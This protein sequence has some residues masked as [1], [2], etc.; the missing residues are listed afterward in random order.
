MA[1]SRSGCALDLYN[2][3]PARL[4]DNVGNLNIRP[5]FKHL[6]LRKHDSILEDATND[7]RIDSRSIYAP[8]IRTR[9]DLTAKSNLQLGFQ[10]FLSGG[11]LTWTG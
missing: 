6:F 10:A 11:T 9:F 4:Y 1:P 5:M 3:Q 7:G 2:G 8:I